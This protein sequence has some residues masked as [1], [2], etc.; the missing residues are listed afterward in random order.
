MSERARLAVAWLLVGVLAV[1][2]LF[3]VA[4]ASV[5]PS[6]GFVAY[7]TAARLLLE[8]A[9]VSRFYDDGWFREQVAR[10]EPR[11]SDIYNVNPPSTAL[12]LLPL[13]SLSHDAARLAWTGLNLVLLLAAVTV[14]LRSLGLGGGWQAMAWGLTLVIQPVAAN[15]VLGQAYVL[16]LA[17]LI[18]AWLGWQRTRPALLGGPLGAMLALKAGGLLIWPLLVQRQPWRALVAGAAAAGAIVVASLPMTGLD[19]WQVY[20]ALLIDFSGGPELSVTAYQSMFSLLRRL[21][22]FDTQWNPAPLFDAPLLG[23]VAPWLALAVVLAVSAY[24]LQRTTEPGPAFAAFVITSVAFS[25]VSLDYHYT[26]LLVPLFILLVWAIRQR[27]P[28]V[29]AVWALSALA[30][31]LDLPYRSP[32][33]ESSAWVLLAYPKLCG[34]GLL[35]ALA[36]WA[37]LRPRSLPA[38]KHDPA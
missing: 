38:V 6:H 30:I 35:W 29:W 1:R 31:G 22:V 14:L 33:L 4:R 15:F 37:C 24:G 32:R 9:P 17:L 8:G 12:M 5:T 2:F 28:A 7:Y 26:L 10:F 11:T 23:A 3:V 25:P 20:A 27:S 34:A 19:A 13:A 21:T 18:L 36:T 16:L